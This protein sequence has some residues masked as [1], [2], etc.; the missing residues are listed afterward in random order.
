MSIR[1]DHWIRKMALEHGMIEPFEPH[2]VRESKNAT[3]ALEA[4]ERVIDKYLDSG[5][6]ILLTHLSPDCQILLRKA[7]PNFGK[8]IQSSIEDPRY[9]VVTDLMDA[10][11]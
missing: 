1:P 5:K 6:D 9:H 4:L 10:E 8:Y 7:N 3:G 2:L 11:V